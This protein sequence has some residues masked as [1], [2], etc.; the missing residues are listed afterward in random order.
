MLL[1]SFAPGQRACSVMN[2][3]CDV[4]NKDINAHSPTVET[5][6]ANAEETR[7]PKANSFVNE[8]IE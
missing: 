3:G 5:V 4:Y 1:T 2:D 6:A 8:G 7:A